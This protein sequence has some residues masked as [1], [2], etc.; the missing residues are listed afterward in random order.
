MVTRTIESND[1]NGR[2]VLNDF[3]YPYEVIALY[4]PGRYV[5]LCCG[6]LPR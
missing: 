6:L 4:C 1:E 3:R 2:L 5:D